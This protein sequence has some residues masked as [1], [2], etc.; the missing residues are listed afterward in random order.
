MNTYGFDV[1]LNGEQIAKAGLA[2]KNYVISCTLHTLHRKDG[3]EE[4][5]LYVGGLDTEGEQHVGWY[6]EALKVGDKI[7]FEV[8][9]GPFDPPKTAGR[10]M[11]EE[12]IRQHKIKHYLQLK[13]ELKDYLEE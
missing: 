6:S 12:E 9:E 10:K 11:S 5:C 1:T 4:M 7:S 13:E 8:I 2:K 3:S